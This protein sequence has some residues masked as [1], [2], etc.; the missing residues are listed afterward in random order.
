M[1]GGWEKRQQLDVLG[2]AADD[3][4]LVGYDGDDLGNNAADKEDDNRDQYL[5]LSVQQNMED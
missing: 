3:D 4:N 5:G 1:A 2:S